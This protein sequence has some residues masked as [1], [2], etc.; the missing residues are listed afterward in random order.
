MA[1]ETNG[2]KLLC[3]EVKTKPAGLEL[4][5]AAPALPIVSTPEV[6]VEASEETLLGGGVLDLTWSDCGD[7]DTHVK[8][9]KLVPSTL[10]LGEETP[11]VGTGALD[12]DVTGGSY[13]IRVQASVVDKTYEGDI[14]EQAT[15][16]LPLWL[17]SLSWD[18]LALPLA[19]GPA[20]DV[21]I[22]VKL[23]QSL[24]AKLATATIT[25]MAQETN[26][27]KLLCME[28]KTKPAETSLIV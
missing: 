2:H 27:H 8:V 14:S 18:G 3:M 23:A 10:T 4:V 21:G 25:I 1:Q 17:G 28:V 6:A 16:D 5:E 12:E 19:K 13:T 26:G 22:K 24:P 15:H 7:A 20:V 11:V 9:Q